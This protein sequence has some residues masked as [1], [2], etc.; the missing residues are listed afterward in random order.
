MNQQ[1]D[2]LQPEIWMRNVFS[3]KAVNRGGVIR[4]SVRD[5]ERMV[6]RDV[7]V[8]ELNR[9]GFHAVENAG[10]MVI[11]CNQEAVRLVC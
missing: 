6:G 9:R 10:Q 5:I 11:F 8:G 1:P 3:A 2:F 7:F 4:R